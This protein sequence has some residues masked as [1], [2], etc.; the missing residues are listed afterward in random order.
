[1]LLMVFSFTA[2]SY[3]GTIIVVPGIIIVRI[4]KAKSALRPGKRN[5]AMQNASAEDT[6]A[7]ITT[8]LTD[9]TIL[10]KKFPRNFFW[11]RMYL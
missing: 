7:E 5:L 1:M 9:T 4:I 11:L 10:F 3:C 6:T 8:V 2:S